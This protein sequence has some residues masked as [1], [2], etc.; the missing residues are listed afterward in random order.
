MYLIV[1]HCTPSY[2]IIS[3]CISLNLNCWSGW[4]NISPA[5][6]RLFSSKWRKRLFRLILTNCTPLYSHELYDYTRRVRPERNQFYFVI[7]NI[8]F[9]VFSYVLNFEFWQQNCIKR[10]LHVLY[11][12]RS[13]SKFV[14]IRCAVIKFMTIHS[15]LEIDLELIKLVGLFSN[16]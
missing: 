4:R 13:K 3:L 2:L 10:G 5:A 9:L 1:L 14:T 15:S 12:V 16:V 11:G 8:I 7:I 6:P